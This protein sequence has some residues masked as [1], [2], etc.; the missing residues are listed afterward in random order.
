MT[1]PIYE[2]P[3]LEITSGSGQV[4]AII[5]GKSAL[6]KKLQAILRLQEIVTDLSEIAAGL[7]YSHQAN[8]V[9]WCRAVRFCQTADK[10]LPISQKERS[11]VSVQA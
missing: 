4:R 7:N 6:A 1:A 5:I 3:R 9:Y 11:I 2:F 8:F 10:I